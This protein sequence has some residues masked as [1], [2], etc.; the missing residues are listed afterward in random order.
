MGTS[1]KKNLEHEQISDRDTVGIKI[2]ILVAVLAE[3]ITTRKRDMVL[4]IMGCGPGRLTNGELG[5]GDDSNSYLAFHFFLTAQ[6]FIVQY[7]DERLP[8]FSS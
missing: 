2:S 1:D 3:H 6:F 8:F 4:V 7:T 5:V